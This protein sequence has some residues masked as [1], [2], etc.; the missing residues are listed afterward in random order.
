MKEPWNTLNC[1][2]SWLATT[3]LNQRCYGKTD[4]FFSIWSFQRRMHKRLIY[5]LINILPDVIL[6]EKSWCNRQPKSLFLKGQNVTL[7][8]HPSILC[9]RSAVWMKNGWWFCI[10]WF[11]NGTLFF[12]IFATV[13]LR[14]VFLEA[15]IGHARYVF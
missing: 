2:I 3:I 5:R 9:W 4:Y 13:V 11:T 1:F 12:I 7:T 10:D 14:L 6:S 15:S 8:P